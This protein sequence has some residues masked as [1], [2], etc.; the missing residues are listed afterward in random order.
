MLIYIRGIISEVA[1]F[2]MLRLFLFMKQRFGNEGRCYHNEAAM[3]AFHLQTF[4]FVV[5]FVYKGGIVLD[6]TIPFIFWLDFY[7]TT[8]FYL[9]AK[10]YLP[11]NFFR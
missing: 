4:W 9:Q 10:E 1:A 8:D 2:K 5:G 6:G 11:G 3:K 7:F